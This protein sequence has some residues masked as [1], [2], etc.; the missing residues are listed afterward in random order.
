MLQLRWH[1]RSPLLLLA[2]TSK[3]SGLRH[4]KVLEPEDGLAIHG[5]GQDEPAFLNYSNMF[6]LTQPLLYM[7]YVGVSS[8]NHSGFAESWFDT[9]ST[10]LRDQYDA[11]RFLIPQIGLSMT[12]DGEGSKAAYEDKVARGEYDFALQQLAIGVANISRPAFIRIGY[13]FNGQW[14]GYSAESYIGAWIACSS[15]SLIASRRCVEQ[16]YLKVALFGPQQ[17]SLCVGFFM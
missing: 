2:V 11:D 9:L 4:L 7:T 3:I 8:L 12:H 6:N 5:A 13:E 16:D 14:N 10:M 17:H 15:A 1:L